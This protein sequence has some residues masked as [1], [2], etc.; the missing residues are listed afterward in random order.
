MEPI[1]A[2]DTERAVRAPAWT[3]NNLLC[4][5]FTD[6]TSDTKLA[7]NG[8]GN[9]Q[10]TISLAPDAYRYRCLIDDHGWEDAWDADEYVP[11]PYDGDDSVI[12]VID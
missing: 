2:R 3:V 10:T 12:V 7:C 11:N 4:R 5:E 8:D 1:L 9:W 6:W